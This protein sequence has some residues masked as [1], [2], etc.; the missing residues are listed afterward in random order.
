MCARVLTILAILLLL[1]GCGD[2]STRSPGGAEMAEKTLNFDFIEEPKHLDPAFIHD[3]Y[4]GAVAG[5]VYDNLVRFGKGTEILPGLAERWDISPDGRRYAFY[6]REAVFS[7]GRP[8]TSADVRYSFTRILRPQT[9]SDRKWLFDRIAGA[10]EV[11]SGITR[12]LSGIKTTNPRTVIIT[13]SAPY[14]AFLAKLAM[15]NAAIIPEG[16][17]GVD[18]PEKAFDAEPIGSGPWVLGKWVHDQRLEFHRNPHYWG[19]K[20]KLD[21]FIYHVQLDDSARRRKFE[22]GDVDVYTLGWTVFRTWFQDP[23]KAKRIVPVP[24]LSTYYIGLM[25]SKPE[26]KDKR[27][28]QAI[29]HGI[30]TAEIFRAFQ[31][32][33]GDLAHGPVP[34][35]VEG[36]RHGIAPRAYDPDRA[37]QLLVEAGVTS[38]TLDLWYRD[39]AQSTEMM[40]AV[41]NDLARIGVTVNLMRRDLAS[42]RHAMY[43]GEA[44]MYSNSWWLDYPHIENAIVP[45]FHSA[46]IPRGGNG[47]HYSS[48][49]LDRLIAEANAEPNPKRQI[50]KFQKAEDFIIEECPWVFL[51][52]RKSFAIT[53]PWVLNY[54]PHLLYNADRFTDV[55]IDLAKKKR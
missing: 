24:E 48:P 17:A 23:E 26:L 21:R 6:L 8:V 43:S 31:G 44:D 38:L 41:K 42:V 32:G 30:N 14:P 35:G 52:H 45:T 46:N 55:N 22:V 16:A 20:P 27:V 39:E 13:L 49:E 1:A 40:T 37:R 4:E 36:F 18:K 5:L 29:A 7:D 3:I 54:T 12:E 9:N 34:P 19:D 33:R 47:A 28:R 11:T 51:Y 53:Q 15:P 2:D 10:D 25:C 50:E